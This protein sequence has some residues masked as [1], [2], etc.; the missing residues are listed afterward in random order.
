MPRRGRTWGV[1]SRRDVRERI[2]WRAVSTAPIAM[3]SHRRIQESSSTISDAL[4]DDLLTARI[5]GRRP[6]SGVVVLDPAI[7]EGAVRDAF[8][9]A[10]VVRPFKTH[11]LADLRLP[12]EQ[13]TSSHHRY[14]ARRA[15]KDL[16]FEILEGPTLRSHRVELLDAFMAMYA[17]LVERHAITDAVRLTRK[18]VSALLC[19]DGA[20]LVRAELDGRTV[21]AM[22][23][24]L[25]GQRV[26]KPP[27]RDVRRRLPPACRVRPVRDGSRS[28]GESW[29]DHCRHRG[30]R[31]SA[32]RS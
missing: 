10:A 8:D 13:R 29:R 25:D 2:C 31:R 26:Y 7:D 21:G 1:F 4:R 9:E 11:H 27:A 28:R 23:W 16:A 15:A 24:L 6:L 12:A 20:Y 3:T 14:Y 19:L 32:R 30:R 22:L 17:V 5:V 18:A